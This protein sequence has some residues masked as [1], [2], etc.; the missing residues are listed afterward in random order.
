[1]KYLLTLLEEHKLWRGE[2]AN[3]PRSGVE[4]CS[5]EAALARDQRG[6]VGSND[7][8]RQLMVEFC[9]FISKLRLDLKLRVG[10]GLIY[11]ACSPCFLQK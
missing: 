5:N 2:S 9:V 10:D 1:M 7:P 11:C 6:A 8:S 3:E 4:M